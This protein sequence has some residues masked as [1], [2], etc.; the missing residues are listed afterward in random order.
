MAEKAYEAERQTAEEKQA[1][2]AP[3]T[4]AEEPVV[5]QKA[6]EIVVRNNMNL[7]K[8]PLLGD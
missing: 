7:G 8:S 6:P 3:E 2:A 4:K 5:S 1:H